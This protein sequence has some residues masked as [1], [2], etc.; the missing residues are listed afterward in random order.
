[1]TILL[2]IVGYILNVILNRWI[3]INIQKI[4]SPIEAIDIR[5][6]TFFV[7]VPFF[8]TIMLLMIFLIIKGDDLTDNKFF[9]WF[10]YTPILLLFILG[11]CKQTIENYPELNKKHELRKFNVKTTTENYSHGGFFLIM[12]SYSSGEITETNVRMYFK[13]C[14][15]SYQLLELPLNML[16]IHINDSIKIPYVILDITNENWTC[17]RLQNMSSAWYNSV[18]VYCKEEDFQPE[19]NI[20]Q[21]K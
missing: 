1:M 15:G 20:N 18:T 9:N 3:S 21:L 2:I 4:F 6:L 14:E 5:L 13:N 8:G 10:K 19:I 11:S 17:T 12:G 7:F 16:K